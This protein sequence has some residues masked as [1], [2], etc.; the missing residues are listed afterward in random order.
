MPIHLF[1]ITIDTIL[2]YVCFV[3]LL[4]LLLAALNFTLLSFYSLNNRERIFIMTCMQTSTTASSMKN[5]SVENID[6]KLH[7]TLL[8]VIVS[9]C[10]TLSYLDAVNYRASD[11]I[12]L[13]YKT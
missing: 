5:S 8:V 9:K 3:L 10:S 7:P 6:Y 1:Q 4:V 12:L 13:S 11:R 2:H